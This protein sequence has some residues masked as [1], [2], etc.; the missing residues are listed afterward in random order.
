MRVVSSVLEVAENLAPLDCRCQHDTPVGTASK[1][2]TVGASIGLG[3]IFV[4]SVP[5]IVKNT[6]TM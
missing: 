6:L 2:S 1:S 5:T 3:L 4:Y